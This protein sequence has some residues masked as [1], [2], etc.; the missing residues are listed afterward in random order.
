MTEHII[1]AFT[2]IAAASLF[3]IALTLIEFLKIERAKEARSVE[4]FKEL[5]KAL[6]RETSVDLSWRSDIPKPDKKDIE[7]MIKD[8]LDDKR[9]DT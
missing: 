4:S 6:G 8:I 3:V 9:E 5:R 1:S 2:A 7:K